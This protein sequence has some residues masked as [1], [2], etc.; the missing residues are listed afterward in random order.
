MFLVQ[1]LHAVLFECHTAVV[2]IFT[3]ELNLFMHNNIIVNFSICYTIG[4]VVVLFS[5]Y[6][7]A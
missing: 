5:L 3:K 4:M 1:R 6:V 2:P 7:C